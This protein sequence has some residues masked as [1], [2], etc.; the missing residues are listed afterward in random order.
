MPTRNSSCP[1]ESG[2]RFKQCC[3]RLGEPGAEPAIL[4]PSDA[5]LDA[6]IAA[7]QVEIFRQQR[8]QGLGRPIISFELRGARVVIVGKRFYKGRWT[9]FFDFLTDYIKDVFGRDWGENEQRKPIDAQHPVMRWAE[10][11]QRQM[12]RA[13]P[14]KASPDELF[15]MPASGA[16]TAWFELAYDLYL[17][18]HHACPEDGA[19]IDAL[20]SRLRM[21][22]EFYGARHEVRAAGLLLRAGFDVSWQEGAG[23]RRG[24]HGE[25]TAS[26]PA[27]GK[28]FWVECKCRQGSVRS[29]ERFTHLITKALRKH[30]EHERLLFIELDLPQKHISQDGEGWPVWAASTLRRLEN[31]ADPALPPAH[32]VLSNYPYHRSLEGLGEGTGIILEGFRTDMYGFGQV[33]SLQSA[34]ERR[35][36]HPELE[37][38]WSSIEVHGHIPP[39]FDASF[40][41][42]DEA[43]RLSIGCAYQLD[44]DAVGILESAIV[45]ED[46]RSAS[47]IYRLTSGERMIYDTPLSDAEMHA[48]K[49]DPRT[50]F[51]QLAPPSGSMRG[52]LD[53]YDFFVSSM[54]AMSKQELLKAMQSRPDF[55][56]I[57]HLSQ[58]ELLHLYVLGL[59]YNLDQRGSFPAPPEW[60]RKLRHRRKSGSST[61]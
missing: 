38:L 39:T 24:G 57:Q 35:R 17:V 28:R 9:L 27:T 49:S 18:H 3:G 2:L 59:V 26:H 20:I 21:S 16:A 37:A 40:P 5:K 46:T 22:S 15:S 33:I 32:V 52:P 54:E 19:A 23:R 14:H 43:T 36:S 29:T 8:Q 50:F 60:M 7:R 31:S 55:D 34:V 45:N 44:D 56:E 4:G 12:E 51:W 42:V 10:H 30:A 53:A 1:C 13:K 6:L 61:A 25:F 47:G 41:G 58:F 48:W 11:L